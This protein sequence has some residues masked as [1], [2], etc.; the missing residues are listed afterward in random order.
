M[1]FLFDEYALDVDRRELHRGQ[2]VVPVPPQVFDL[3]EYLIRNNERVVTKDDLISA[4]WNGRIISDAAL[5]TRLNAAR[6]AIGDTGEKQ[7]LIKT[8]PRKGF[9]FVGA[10]QEVSRRTVDPLGSGAQRSDAMPS[11]STAPRLS[12]V[13]LPFANIGGGLEQDY[14]VDGVTESL[15][16]DLSRISGSFV[17]ARNTAFTFKNK[18]VDVRKIGRELNVRYVLEGSVQRSGNRLRV[19]VQLIDAETGQHLWAERFDK[20]VADLF[21]MQDEIVSR[22]ANALDAELVLA[23]AKRAERA[24]NPNAL[25]LYFQGMVWIYKGPT[26]ENL[27]TARAFFERA[28]NVDPNSV[29]ALLGKGRVEAAFGSTFVDED[30]WVHCAAAEPLLT[31]VLSLAP[32]NALAHAFL[33]VVQ[34]QTKR[35]ESGIAECERAL[36]L[37][38]NLANAWGMIA[39]GKQL[40][41]YAEQSVLSVQEAERLSPRDIFAFRWWNTAGVSKM[42]LG[43]DAAAVRWLRRCV[44]E[45]RNYSIAH[46][47]LAAALALSGELDEGRAAGRA[48]IALDPNFSIRRYR[49]GAASDNPMYLAGRERICLGLQIAG[50][51]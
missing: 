47:H 2:E 16:T 20:P 1:R 41:G 37:D 30:R 14:F 50:L 27:T 24:L 34:M 26:R 22:L 8:L 19:A 48:G 3:I 38:R 11:P 44:E 13:V 18:P 39:Y 28:L 23:E 21:D 51:P 12:M 9:R 35:V 5:T 46:I 36:T 7:R 4:I 45:N 15:T 49:L 25:E 6:N 17:I 31:R 33:G 10:V 40:L 29:E 43:E 32:N 42:L